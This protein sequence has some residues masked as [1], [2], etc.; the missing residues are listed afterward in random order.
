VVGDPQPERHARRRF[1]KFDH[2][3]T[4]FA[5]PDGDRV[6]RR[7]ASG[8]FRL[9]RHEDVS[10]GRGAESRKGSRIKEREPDQKRELVQTPQQAV[11]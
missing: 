11:R 10:E 5:A 1:R 9:V 6:G 2:Q 3:G 4:V 7:A 8:R